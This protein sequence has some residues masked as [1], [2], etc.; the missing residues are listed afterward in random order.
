MGVMLDHLDQGVFTFNRDFTI[1]KE[2]SKRAPAILG[3]RDV[4]TATW[5]QL[6][7]VDAPTLGAFRQWV[8]LM[9]GPRGVRNLE[10][11]AHLNPIQEMARTTDDGVRYVTLTCRPIVRDGQVWRFLA[12]VTDVTEQRRAGTELQEKRLAQQRESERIVALVR[13]DRPE[14]EDLTGRCQELSKALRAT[15]LDELLETRGAALRRAVHT[16]KGDTGSFGFSALSSCLAGVEE[17]LFTDAATSTPARWA[18]SLA[19]LDAELAAI[20]EWRTRLFAE[21]ADRLSVDQ[22]TYRTLV[23]DLS[24]GGLVDPAAILERLRYLPAR[25][26]RDHSRRYQYIVESYRRTH[27]KRLADLHVATPDM[28][29]PPHMMRI[30]DSSIV[31]LLRNA[32]DHGIESDQD[33]TAAGKGPGRVSIEARYVEDAI[34]VTVADDGRGVDVAAVVAA[35][36]R[37]G[38]VTQGQAERL[39][40]EERLRLVLRHGVTTRATVGEISGRG[41]GLDAVADELRSRSG[42]FHIVSHPGR[43]AAM[44]IRLPIVGHANGRNGTGGS[45]WRES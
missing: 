32:V 15:T 28:A 12:L 23:D 29:I 8:D 36:I 31:Q 25:R 14:V 22:K 41:V 16:L 7:P 45:T 1:N 33:R 42:S 43:G 2:Y 6:L 9:A 10:R 18:S 20:Q 30:I 40:A 44:T 13:S 39:T 26:L 24:S 4:P 35:A 3:V 37:A 5:E 27:G 21:R 19:A 17:H 11:F 34:E 38:V